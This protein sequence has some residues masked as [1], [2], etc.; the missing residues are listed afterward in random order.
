MKKSKKI[1]NIFMVMISLVCCL[2]MFTA[3]K[4]DN[5]PEVIAITQSMIELEYQT[6]VY[7]RL[8]KTPTV[9]LKNGETTINSAEYSVEYENN[10][11]VGTAKVTVTAKEGS[12]VVS[13]S[14]SK[15]F[16]I[17]V[18]ELPELVVDYFGKNYAVYDG[19]AKN[20]SVSI[21]GLTM[22][23][24]DLSWEYKELNAA[25]D[26]YVTLNTL[27]N[28]FVEKG[29]Y[30]VT[31][32]GK[33][34]YTG[35]VTAVYS[36]YN[37]FGNVTLSSESAD[38]TGAS[39]IP[40]ATVDGLVE[41]VDYEISYAYKAP[42]ET[43]F[44]SYEVAEGKENSAFVNAGV[45]R[46]IATGKGI[47]GG[48][49]VATFTI[50]AINLPAINMSSG[51]VYDGS[52]KTPSYSV[53]SLTEN[54]HY[55]IA[56]FYRPMGGTFTEY[57]LNPLDTLNFINAGEYKLVVTGIGNYKN[58]QETIYTIAKATISATVS[59]TNYTYNGDKGKL[60]TSVAISET[61]IITYYYKAGTHTE[62]GDASEWAKYS[63]DLNLNAGVYS[64]YS[65]VSGLVNYEDT[66][67]AII[68]F[69]V[70]KD[71]LKGIPNLSGAEYIYDGQSH[72][73][74]LQV[75]A[76]LGT[77][78]LVEGVDYVLQWRRHDGKND[79]V[80]TPD[81]E[82]PELNFVDA[83]IYSVKLYGYGNYTISDRTAINCE[84]YFQIYPATMDNFTVQRQGYVYGTTPTDFELKGVNGAKGA[85]TLG[86]TITYSVK[87]M[88]SDSNPWVTIT[89]DTVLEAG[90]YIIRATASG[91]ANYNDKS[92][93]PSQTESNLFTVSGAYLAE[94]ALSVSI[95]ENNIETL[96]VT[97]DA[98]VLEGA[99]IT[100]YYYAVGSEG[101][102][103]ILEEDTVLEAGEYEIYAVVSNMKNYNDF[104][105][106]EV[107]Y[108][109]EAEEPE[110]Q[111][112]AE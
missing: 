16:E 56:W 7:D 89:K 36:I 77:Q 67:T 65:V 1:F 55:T 92:T 76:K 96:T 64:L 33:G 95:T 15:E 42:G 105:T 14:A 28:N 93:T 110:V 111:E 100:Y 24:Y 23:D 106:N 2:G 103:A 61:P 59:K 38:Y 63:L 4:K 17:I 31:A 85:V 35:E 29:N 18:A 86:A 48:E 97:G 98:T 101:G 37:A 83:G 45:Y 109:V 112:P 21:S 79:V 66:T 68:Q 11:N 20:P 30:K 108:V 87:R 13:G 54:Q 32:T 80:Y 72:D 71:E 3:C 75:Y 88:G 107:Y 74:Q 49:K 26:D 46:V 70:Y 73:P 41:G 53:T 43:E 57:N 91:V 104:R 44:V 10:T 94:N 82:H 12:T 9:V 5:E 81:P 27:V 52:S 6:V 22:T 51:V 8:A 84:T 50:N 25:D 78:T 40:T 90:T 39:H 62:I 47:Y 34:N 102:P 69:E 60:N 58:T 99:T 19:D